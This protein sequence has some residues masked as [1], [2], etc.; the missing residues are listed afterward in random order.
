MFGTIGLVDANDYYTSAQVAFDPALAQRPVVVLS[1]ND[2]CIVSRNKL[3]KKLGVGM[4]VPLFEVR[5]LL[6][7]HHAVILSS[8]FELYSDLSWRFQGVLEEFTPDIEHYSIDEVFLRLP[9][10]YQKSLVE[11]GHEMRFRVKALTG[12]PVSVG[13]ARTKTLAKIA[14]EHAKKSEKA[15][16]VVDITDSRYQEVAL[17]RV[18]VVDVWGVGR[19]YS[20]MLE[21]NGIRTALDL[22]NADDN[23]VRKKMT[24]KGLRTV[25]ELRGIPCLPLQPTPAMKQRIGVLRSFGAA[26][27]SVQDIRAAIA[28]FTAKAAEKL[29]KNNLVAGSMAVYV[30]TDRYKEGPQ[31][32][33][34]VN[35]R[36]A[37]KSDS[38]LELLRLAMRGLEKIYPGGFQI[39]KAGT[40]LDALELAGKSPKRL[41]ENEAY[42][43]QRRLMAAVDDLNDRYG[44]ETVRCGLFPSSGVW[45]TRFERRSPNY[46]T[47]WSQIM[48]AR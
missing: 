7:K 17:E 6:E 27:D 38:T 10:C 30:M 26:S 24:V 44:G 11:I 39:R 14:I 36:V 1:N 23:W 8:N 28:H 18:P 31:Y 22:R 43:R 2:G 9:L 15:N 40:L 37:P 19:R 42:E 34:S 41:W 12:I 45:R 35:I 13:F 29:R 46:T 21:T 32:D 16:G 47:D 48:V 33:N 3:A 25:Y 4:A 20:L 5:E